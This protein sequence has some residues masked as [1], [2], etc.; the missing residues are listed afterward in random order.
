MSTI[1]KMISDLKEVTVAAKDVVKELRE[2]AAEIIGPEDDPTVIDADFDVEEPGSI[3]EPKSLA[4]VEPEEEEPE[5]E[6]NRP[7]RPDG[8]QTIACPCGEVYEAMIKKGAQVSCPSCCVSI[9]LPVSFWCKECGSE[10]SQVYGDGIPK[11]CSACGCQ[12]FSEPTAQGKKPGWDDW[13]E[14]EKVAPTFKPKL[15]DHK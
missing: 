8:I 6:P 15:K 2:T 10:R 11:Q 5:V 13:N 7:Y 1:K 4:K 14:A 12:D 9:D 3:A